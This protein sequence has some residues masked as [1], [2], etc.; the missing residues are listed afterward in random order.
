MNETC[1]EPAIV[2][3]EDERVRLLNVLDSQVRMLEKYAGKIA[4]IPQEPK[5]PV[6]KPEPYEDSVIGK[7]AESNRKLSKSIEN[8]DAILRHFHCCFGEPREELNA[9]GKY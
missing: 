4:N 1:E 8:I 6:E 3:A 9:A 7:I 5:C 2:I